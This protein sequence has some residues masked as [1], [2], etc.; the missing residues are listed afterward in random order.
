MNLGNDTNNDSLGLLPPA[1]Y[2][3][4]IV[5]PVIQRNVSRHTSSLSPLPTYPSKLTS[6]LI[7]LFQVL[8]NP[9]WYTAYTPYSPEQSQG[10]LESL[11]NFQTISS[12]LTGLPISNASLLDEATAAA[13]AMAMCLATSHKSASPETKGKVFI[14]S[15]GVSP[16]TLAVL[17]T[18]SKGFGITVQSIPDSEIEK[19]LN[20]H[21]I[22]VMLQY[23]D[24][25]GGIKDYESLTKA[26]KAVGGKV[27]V[28]SDLLALTMLKPPGE[29]GADVVLGNSAR[30]GESRR[31][32]FFSH[33]WQTNH[34]QN[35]L[36]VTLLPSRRT[37]WIRW[38]PCRFLRLH[39]RFEKEDAWKIGRTI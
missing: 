9:A 11:I 19:N 28:A 5:P 17:R 37:S 25:N 14:V 2:H 38:S 8:E 21:V 34:T 36:T 15:Q 39:R 29:W 16:S 33:V 13:E 31:Q 10:R 23:P 6:H 18:R 4:A 1:R 24:V 12:S 3:N 7:H 22:G 35:T 27:V 26:I 32:Q 20:D 30:F